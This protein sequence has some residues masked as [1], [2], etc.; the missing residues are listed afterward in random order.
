MNE[1]CRAVSYAVGDHMAA[2]TTD[3]FMGAAPMIHILPME[4]EIRHQSSKP[5]QSIM[6]PKG[7]ITR[8][9]WT[10]CNRTLLTS[11]DGG[12][13]RQWDAETGERRCL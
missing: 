2:Y 4:Q 7:R 1:P 8:V 6:A 11:H 13:L 3:A 12:F 9:I 10:D 5:V